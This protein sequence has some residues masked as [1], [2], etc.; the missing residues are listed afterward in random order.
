MDAH[1]FHFGTQTRQGEIKKLVPSPLRPK[2]QIDVSGCAR[3]ARVES[4]KKNISNAVVSGSD[5][6]LF[7]RSRAKISYGRFSVTALERSEGTHTSDGTIEL[8]ASPL[9]YPYPSV[10]IFEFSRRLKK[11]CKGKCL[12]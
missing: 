9:A 10:W 5:V 4:D 1:E 3:F 2:R 12:R 8:H 6:V 7:L 11:T